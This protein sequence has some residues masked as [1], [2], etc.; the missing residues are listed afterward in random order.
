MPQAELPTVPGSP[1]AHTERGVALRADWVAFQTLLMKEI[2]RFLRIWPQTLVPPAISMALYFLIFGRFIGARIGEMGGLDYMAFIVPGLIMMSVITNAYSNV[3]SS[4]YSTKFQRSIEA[5]L[6]S[7]TPPS[8]ILAGFVAG[9]IARGL[10]VGFLVT[11]L[12]G[13]FVEFRIHNLAITVGILILTAMLFSL[14][15]FI[16][17]VFADKFDDIS[18]IPAFVL[19]PLT[20]LGGVFYSLDLLPDFWRTLSY[21]N[22]IVYMVASFRYGLFGYSDGIPVGVSFATIAV[23][24]TAFWFLSLWLLRRGTGLR[25]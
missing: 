19:T 14:G 13:F 15:G 3:A 21:F 8:V 16:N 4:F 10:I 12:A 24:V 17:A 25:T 18:I 22:P 2:R 6:V 20:Y 7:P 11:V 5:I 1:I 23:F 9:G